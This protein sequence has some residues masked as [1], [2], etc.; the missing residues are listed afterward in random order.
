MSEVV[1]ELAPLTN[2]KAFERNKVAAAMLEHLTRQPCLARRVST[3]KIDLWDGIGVL[4]QSLHDPIAAQL[5]GEVLP[6]DSIELDGTI[7]VPGAPDGWSL[8]RITGTWGWGEYR[9]VTVLST[10]IAGEE[11]EVA[12]GAALRLGSIL[13]ID[14]EV[15]LVLSGA[16]KTFQVRRGAI[17]TEPQPHNSGAKVQMLFLPEDLISASKIVDAVNTTPRVDLRTGERELGEDNAAKL[18]ALLS[19]YRRRR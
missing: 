1:Y 4:P 17:G 2:Q 13:K 16:D 18:K 11:I 12:D 3:M 10:E 5:E 19:R 14:E 8:L 15:I 6:L 7:C 9:Q